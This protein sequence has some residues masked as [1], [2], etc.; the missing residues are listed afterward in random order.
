METETNT[1]T[2]DFK[3]QEELILVL[4]GDAHRTSHELELAREKLELVEEE[5]GRYKNRLNQMDVIQQELMLDKDA[6]ER[7]LAKSVQELA[8]VRLEAME[9]VDVVENEMRMQ[10]NKLSRDSELRISEE[11][12]SAARVREKFETA[13]AEQK[14]QLL[15]VHAQI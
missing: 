8:Q 3:A 11:I 1:V 7:N 5:L 13:L 14:L 15:K 6:V 4:R 9:K 10:I 12:N 2:M